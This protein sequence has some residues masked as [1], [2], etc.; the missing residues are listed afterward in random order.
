[1]SEKF[2]NP[3]Q[4]IPVRAPK[5]EHLID[6]QD[7]NALK[8]VKNTFVRHDYW[9]KQGKSGRI[10]CTL[11][12]LSPLVVG[13]Q[14]TAGNKES[15]TEGKVEPYRNR[16]GEVAIPANSLRGMITNIAEAIS[17][18]SM[19]VLDTLE[20][21]FYSTRM[22]TEEAFKDIGLLCKR[23]EQWFIFPLGEG[24]SNGNYTD[25]YDSLFLRNHECFQAEKNKDFHNSGVFYI[26]GEHESMPK[27]LHETFL[28]W[29][30]KIVDKELITVDAEQIK[31][32]EQ[33]LRER[34]AEEPDFPYLPK[35]Y[36]KQER[37]LSDKSKPIL[38]DGDL[39]YYKSATNLKPFRRYVKALS[40]SAIG[41]RIVDG[42][43]MDAFKRIGGKNILPW[44]DKRYQLTPADALFGVVEDKPAQNK[45]S[46]NLAARIRF[47]DAELLPIST[48]M[49]LLPERT[50]K[51]LNSPKPPSPTM[52]FSTKKS[53]YI[54][55]GDLNLNIHDPN[56]RKR[57]LPHLKVGKQDVQYHFDTK[58]T[59]KDY[60]PHLHLKCQP[61]DVGVQFQFVVHFDNL[62]PAE[63]ELL[64]ISLVP[65]QNFLHRLGLGKPLGLGHVRIT[66]A[67]VEL[68][69]RQ[70]RYSLNNL[71]DHASEKYQAFNMAE[72]RVSDES[73]IDQDTLDELL[74][75]SKPE[76]I[77]YPVCYPYSKFAN[78]AKHNEKDGFEWFVCND[79]VAASEDRGQFLRR[80]NTKNAEG[81]L[82]IIPTLDAD[83]HCP[84]KTQGSDNKEKRT[85][86]K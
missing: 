5:A 41:R 26:R 18:S 38:L 15:K 6:Y 80:L 25:E 17:H 3:Y 75:M 28:H 73:L 21:E 35:G 63:L 48:N 12:T 70:Q 45:D 76:N 42:N 71:L 39:I 10:V 22:R 51:I 19:R 54:S 4:F 61:I 7:L 85:H 20:D 29:N 40:Y 44:N 37:G 11:K 46:R 60:R 58:T 78:Q 79:R 23:N 24:E 68:I 64:Y 43:L 36:E 66:T 86:K 81:E 30:G 67:E 69:N 62:S 57:Y 13:G 49:F 9:H 65:E 82:E 59:G 32:F 1:M 8:A 34:Y 72:H 55:K 47:T 74:A 33:L 56:G 2:Y 31:Q 27:K 14:Q 16:T 77:H 50:L 53:S 83:I 84:A 52:Y